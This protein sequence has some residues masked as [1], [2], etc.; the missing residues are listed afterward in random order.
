MNATSIDFFFFLFVTAGGQGASSSSLFH[1]FKEFKRRIWIYSPLS[2]PIP[3]F[4]PDAHRNPLFIDLE[5]RLIKEYKDKEIMSNSSRDSTIDDIP[6]RN[7]MGRKKLTRKERSS[8]TQNLELDDWIEN[9][10][11]DLYK[12]APLMLMMVLNHQAFLITQYLLTNLPRA[13][14]LMARHLLVMK[15]IS[16]MNTYN[17]F[18]SPEPSH[19]PYEHWEVSNDEI[20][21]DYEKYEKYTEAIKSVTAKN[22][23]IFLV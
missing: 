4:L 2:A 16:L 1:F 7:G 10:K 11:L 5:V 14:R 17:F 15:S 21:L 9:I 8:L 3:H 22:R 23:V 13:R 12:G 6:L 20:D 18:V 19:I